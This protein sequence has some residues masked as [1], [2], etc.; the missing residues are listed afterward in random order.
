MAES[1]CKAPFTFDHPHSGARDRE[2]KTRGIV[3]VD[4]AHAHAAYA[5]VKAVGCIR[6][7]CYRPNKGALTHGRVKRAAIKE[8]IKRGSLAG[9]INSRSSWKRSSRKRRN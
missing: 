2:E 5:F 7:W 4:V 9:I 6:P 1:V 3:V 8:K